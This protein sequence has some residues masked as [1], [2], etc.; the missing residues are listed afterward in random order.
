MQLIEG[1]SK[2]QTRIREDRKGDA[3]LRARSIRS[4]WSGSNRA[5]TPL[6]PKAAVR[7]LPFSEAELRG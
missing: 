2:G 5:P 4:C 1:F 3:T 7:A 6:A